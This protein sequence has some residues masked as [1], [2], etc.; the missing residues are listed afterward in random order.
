MLREAP[1]RLES[2]DQFLDSELSDGAYKAST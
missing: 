1:V 2:L